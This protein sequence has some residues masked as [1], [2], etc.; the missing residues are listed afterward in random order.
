MNINIK[1]VNGKILFSHDCENNTL[2]KTLEYAKVRG[3]DLRHADLRYADL[4]D[5]NLRDANLR[6]ADLRYADLRYADLR[7]ADLIVLTLPR[8]TAYVQIKTVRI[9][10]QHHTHDQWMAFSDSDIDEMNPEALAWWKQYGDLVKAAI[11]SIQFN[12]EIK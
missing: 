2:I 5:A 1:H 7:Y 4:R 6:Y 3:T 10:C 8:W 9:G 12:R 11:N